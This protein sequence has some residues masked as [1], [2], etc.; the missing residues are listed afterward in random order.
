MGTCF[1]QTGRYREHFVCFGCRTMLKKTAYG[2]LP[3]STRA[4][5]YEQYRTSCPHCGQPI[6][7][8]GKEF[9]PPKRRRTK[10]WREVEARRREIQSL[11]SPHSYARNIRGA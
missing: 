11:T 1:C 5:T 4:S 7:N 8:M 10:A 9:Q 6:H 3:A 2:E